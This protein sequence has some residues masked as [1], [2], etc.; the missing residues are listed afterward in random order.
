[1]WG[2]GWVVVFYTTW[3]VCVC[4]RAIPDILMLTDVLCFGADCCVVLIVDSDVGV[5]VC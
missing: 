3:F 2:K 1:M 5:F 4:V